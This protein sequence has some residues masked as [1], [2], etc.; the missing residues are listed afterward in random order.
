MYSF[1]SQGVLSLSNTI[2]KNST[3]QGS[4]VVVDVQRAI[5]F[6]TLFVAEARL[7]T[8]AKWIL[9]LLTSSLLN[10]FFYLMSL[11]IGVGTF[12][13]ARA[14]STG[15]DGEKYIVFLAPALLASVAIQD[16][17]SEVTFPVLQGFK[18]DKTYFAMNATPLGGRQIALGTDFSS[19]LRTLG[20]VLIYFAVLV[21]FGAVQPAHAW[22]MMITSI[23]AA[24]CFAAVMLAAAAATENDDLF[25]NLMGRL[26]IMPLFLFSGT[27]Y[28]LASMPLPLQVIGWISP[29]WHSTELGRWVSYGH[30]ISTEM[31]FVHFIYLTALLI[32]GLLWAFN[33]FE[34][35]LSK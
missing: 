18:W 35:R 22:P 17:M 6:G 1:V 2:N 11:G 33:R 10:P 25:L 13:N 23:Y 30:H 8:M 20:S 31:I 7:R 5:R 16:F 19:A 34:Y 12:V 26:L 32:G 21:S 3:R 15:I 14:G 28:P 9:S 27:F 29:L 24:G 4:L